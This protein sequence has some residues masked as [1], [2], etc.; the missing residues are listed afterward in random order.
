M[1][2]QI[3]AEHVFRRLLHLILLVIEDDRLVRSQLALS[4]RH[5]CE[6]VSASICAPWTLVLLHLLRFVGLINSLRLLCARLLVLLNHTS[7]LF[8]SQNRA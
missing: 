8:V 1:F 4:L 3:R 6:Q 2:L 7:V 5:A